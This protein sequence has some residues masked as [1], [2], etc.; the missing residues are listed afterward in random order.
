MSCAE[1]DLTI[2]KSENFSFIEKNFPIVQASVYEGAAASR[3][4]ATGFK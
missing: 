3:V 2:T 1:Q 4:Y